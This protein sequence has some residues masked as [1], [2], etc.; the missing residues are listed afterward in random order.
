MFRSF[1]ALFAEK[2]VAS[3]PD[4]RISTAFRPHLDRIPPASRPHFNRVP[5]TFRPHSDRPRGSPRPRTDARWSRSATRRHRLPACRCRSAVVAREVR[6]SPAPTCRH[7]K[8]NTSPEPCQ[9]TF[10]RKSAAADRKFF[11]ARNTFCHRKL[12]PAHRVFLKEI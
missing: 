6:P 4:N 3:R 1:F 11:C 8:Y 12:P 10:V 5:T 9:Y 7:C 2:V